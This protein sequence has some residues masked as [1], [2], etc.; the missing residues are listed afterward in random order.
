M[1]C[2]LSVIEGRKAVPRNALRVASH[3]KRHYTCKDTA[4]CVVVGAWN[5]FMTLR[6][7]ERFS[8]RLQLRVKN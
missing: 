1:M 3:K 6:Y 8:V 7:W 5:G 4:V 2:L